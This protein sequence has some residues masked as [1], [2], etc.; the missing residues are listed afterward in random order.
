MTAN[1]RVILDIINESYEHLT[2]EEIFMKLKNKSV[3]MVLATVYNNLNTLCKDGLVRRIVIEGQPERYDK[4]KRHDH[5]VCL[6]CGKISDIYLNDYTEKF[7]NDLHLNI[8]F[9]DLKVF[10]LCDECREKEEGHG[11][12]SSF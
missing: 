8:K 7:R 4:I 9:Y 3:K 6:Q 2:A 5:L 11:H 12:K 1:G 10:Y